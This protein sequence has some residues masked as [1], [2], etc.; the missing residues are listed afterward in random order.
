M[1]YYMSIDTR[2]LGISGGYNVH[3]RKEFNEKAELRHIC[4][5][6]FLL[7]GCFW[8]SM[9]VSVAI[10]YRAGLLLGFFTLFYFAVTLSLYFY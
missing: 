1:L 5:F 6:P 8:W 7:E 3:A 4:S 9:P 10:D 2:S